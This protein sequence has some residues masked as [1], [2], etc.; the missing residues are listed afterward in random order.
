MFAA[1][2]AKGVNSIE[3]QREAKHRSL[4]AAKA[5]EEQA[6]KEVRVRVTVHARAASNLIAVD[7]R[8]FSMTS[9]PYVDASICGTDPVTG[10]RHSGE[11]GQTRSLKRTLAPKWDE[12]ILLHSL[13]IALER[14]LP[15]TD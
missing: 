7:N 9:D 5:A 4:L 11:H 14:R 6:A 3:L 10:V 8:Q 15:G 12:W 1:K 2:A 13:P